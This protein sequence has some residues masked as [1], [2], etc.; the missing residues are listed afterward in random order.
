M[1]YDTDNL[2]RMF[3]A[4]HPE[5]SI[6]EYSL[7]VDEETSDVWFLHEGKRN[8]SETLA[9][10]VFLYITKDWEGTYDR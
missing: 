6:G 3:K 10:V 1:L 8:Y 2:K 7:E 5:L 9:E 4:A